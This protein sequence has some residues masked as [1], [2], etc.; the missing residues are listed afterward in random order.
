VKN[1]S[2]CLF[3]RKA[4]LIIINKQEANFHLLYCKSTTL[5]C[6]ITRVCS[7]LRK[8]AS[9]YKQRHFFVL[10]KIKGDAYEQLTMNE[11]L[12]K[13]KGAAILIEI[14]NLTKTLKDSRTLIDHLQLYVV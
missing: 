7:F 8:D 5:W 9:V 11:K 2:H 13:M 12:G 6:S 10:I 14:Q 1:R 3:I 4:N